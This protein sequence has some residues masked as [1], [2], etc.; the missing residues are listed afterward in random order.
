[1]HPQHPLQPPATPA[2][3]IEEVASIVATLED[4]PLFWRSAQTREGVIGMQQAAERFA[5]ATTPA[6]RLDAALWQ[7]EAYLI[8]SRS[9]PDTGHGELATGWAT[10][11]QIATLFGGP[12]VW[13]QRCR[14]E[15]EGAAS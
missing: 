15:F 12:E 3:I 2:Q 6:E 4:S 7:N 1:M 14:A 8:F 10:A 9:L 13:A 11:R 5:A